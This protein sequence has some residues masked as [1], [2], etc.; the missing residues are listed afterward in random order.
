MNRSQEILHLYTSVGELSEGK[1][2]QAFKS[3]VKK[4]GNASKKFIYKNRHKIMAIGGAAGSAYLAHK[5]INSGDDGYQHYHDRAKSEIQKTRDMLS[6]HA[7]SDSKMTK[8][9]DKKYGHVLNKI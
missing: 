1:R 7:K 6:N 3:R 9:M 8:D 5:A 2:W 4:Y